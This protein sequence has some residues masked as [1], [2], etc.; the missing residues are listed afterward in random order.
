MTPTRGSSIRTEPRFVEVRWLPFGI[1]AMTLPPL[2]VYLVR[3][4]GSDGLRCH[5]LVHWRQYE[6]RGLV[7]FYAGYVWEWLRAGCSYDRHPWE[8]EA[9]RISGVR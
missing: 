7:G 9:R 6:E 8:E 1:G 2:G 3:G 4:R 5:E